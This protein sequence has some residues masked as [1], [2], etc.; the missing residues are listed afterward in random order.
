VRV[1][2]RACTHA[3]V[4]ACV[5]GCMWMHVVHVDALVVELLHGCIHGCVQ[6]CMGACMGIYKNVWALTEVRERI[7]FVQEKQLS[8]FSDKEMNFLRQV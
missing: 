4:R 7:K 1:C 3:L 2:V 6:V 5:S 8:I